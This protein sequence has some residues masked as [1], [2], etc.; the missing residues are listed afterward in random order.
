M[1]ILVLSMLLASPV[2]ACS[3]IGSG[4]PCQAAWMSSAV[5][6]GKVIEITEP[7]RAMPLP[8]TG[9]NATG[10]RLANDPTPPP[11]RPLR[12]VRLQIGEVL[13]GVDAAQKEIEILTGK[14]GGDCGYAFQTGFDYMVYA[15]RN[16]QGLMETGICSRTRPLAE[17][18][19]DIAYLRVVPQANPTAEIH[20]SMLDD[21]TW[22]AGR[23][24]MT[25]VRTTL[26][27]PGGPLEAASDGAGQVKFAGLAPGDYTVEWAADGY[28]SGNRKVQVHAKGCA[29]VPVVMLLDRRV[30]GRVTTKAGLPVAKVMIEILPAH[31]APNESPIAHDSATTGD[32]G[33]YLFEYLRTGDYYLG[34]NLDRPPS[35]E[36]PYGRWFFPG[37]E[38]R[39]KAT[40]L[41]LAETPGVQE[42]DL[43]L[44][45]PQQD[46]I[47][48]G[49]V[50]WP[51]GQP[52]RATI[53]L[54]DPRWPWWASGTSTATDDGHFLLHAFDGTHYRLHVVGGR[55]GDPQ[56]V[57]AEPVEIAP[58]SEPLKLRLL[59]TRPG[60]SFRQERE[61]QQRK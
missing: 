49:V 40:I 41:H 24:P 11:A 57:S 36:N 6:T 39:S 29:E 1:R 46:R 42:L 10:R 25:G 52:A 2:W 22:Q 7:P 26:S 35:R 18:A 53:H 13:T 8:S 23:R 34:I 50:L 59:L 5:F 15:Y 4:P 55:R 32:D 47:I 56:G 44:P 3:C 27:G 12:V 33:R 54:E 9:G 43:T 16:A 17:A 21:S 14:G 28:R 45:E 61:Q 37:T 19:E 20:V 60:D 38:D 48:E 31:P 58:G 30:T 51:D